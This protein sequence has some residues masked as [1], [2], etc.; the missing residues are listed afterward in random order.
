MY[1]LRN[2]KH[3]PCFHTVIETSGSLGP[4]GNVLFFFY[5][6]TGTKLKRRNKGPIAETVT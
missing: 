3:F 4:G 1:Y 5:K 2:R 6:I